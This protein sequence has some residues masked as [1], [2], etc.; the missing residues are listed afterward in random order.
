MIHSDLVKSLTDDE[1]SILYYMVHESIAPLGYEAKFEFVKM[2]KLNYVVNY[3]DILRKKALEE[4]G[5]KFDDL[6]KKIIEFYK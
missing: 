2:L 3:I 5:G 6:K 1:A 4:H